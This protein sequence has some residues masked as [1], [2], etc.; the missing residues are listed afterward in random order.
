VRFTRRV[1]AAAMLVM[2]SGASAQT[3]ETPAALDGAK[4]ISAIEAKAAIDTGA[5]PLDVR[6]K[7]SFVEG[8]LPKAKSIG[9]ARNPQ[10]KAFD[11]AAFGPRKDGTL[12]IYGHGSD[13]WSAV[14]A[15]NDAV[16]AGY[17]KVLW[18]RGGYAEWT[19]SG[20]PIEQ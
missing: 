18:L 3:G 20:L 19:K 17:T 10:T 5:Q 2:A 14:A 12:V 13:G 7:A 11:P 16:K 4:T 8:R 9:T 15:V 6:R 1:L